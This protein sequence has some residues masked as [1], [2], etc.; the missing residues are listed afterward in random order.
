MVVSS[1]FVVEDLVLRNEKKF[2]NFLFRSHSMSA[3]IRG[4]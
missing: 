3:L 1:F 4:F 2:C